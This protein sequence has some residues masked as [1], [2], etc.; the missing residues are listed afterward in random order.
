VTWRR[1]G[2]DGSIAVLAM[3]KWSEEAA[4]KTVR[5]L[6][7]VVAQAELLRPAGRGGAVHDN[8]SVL[9]AENL[10]RAELDRHARS[11]YEAEW[12][13]LADA[14]GSEDQSAQVAAALRPAVFFAVALRP[15]VLRPALFFAA[16]LRP[17]VL[18]PALRP[19]LRPAAFLAAPLRAPAFRPALRVPARIANG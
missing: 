16:V 4:R 19:T 14:A 11:D 10:H 12:I 8:P 2:G 18:A 1:P 7:D 3:A 6:S 9:I 15:A 17:A 13:G 5:N